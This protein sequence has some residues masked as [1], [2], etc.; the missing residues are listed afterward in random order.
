ME[1]TADRN[2]P[3]DVT[4]QNR[5]PGMSRF[6]EKLFPDETL[7]K[8][9]IFLSTALSELQLCRLTLSC[10]EVMFIA[11]LAKAVQEKTKNAH[12]LKTQS[13]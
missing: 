10:L 13:T 5:E 3:G 1:R 8:V 11:R 2:F 12:A 6:F 7:Q 9:I 4:K